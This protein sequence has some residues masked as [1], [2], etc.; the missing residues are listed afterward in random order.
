VK[1]PVPADRGSAPRQPAR[2]ARLLRV[3]LVDALGEAVDR[4]AVDA[5]VAEVFAR[6]VDVGALARAAEGDVAAFRGRSASHR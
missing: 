6:G 5:L 2:D 1:A 4:V 3:A